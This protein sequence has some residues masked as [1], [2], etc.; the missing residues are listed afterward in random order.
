MANGQSMAALASF[1]KISTGAITFCFMNIFMATMG[2]ASA[3]VTRPAGRESSPVR[4]ICL[5]P[6]ARNRRLNL[7]RPRRFSKDH[8]QDRGEVAK[9][10]HVRELMDIMLWQNS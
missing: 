5:R 6:P 9:R 1:K 4:C 8:E 3:Q 10:K 2:L 7:E